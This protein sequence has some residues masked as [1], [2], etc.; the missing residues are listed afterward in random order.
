MLTKVCDSRMRGSAVGWMYRGI[1]NILCLG[2]CQLE[3]LGASH[4]L[5]ILHSKERGWPLLID[6]LAFVPAVC[7]FFDEGPSG[8]GLALFSGG[9]NLRFP[10]ATFSLPNPLTNTSIYRHLQTSQFLS[11]FTLQLAC[12]G[13][14]NILLRF[15]ASSLFFD[16]GPKYCVVGALKKL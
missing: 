10:A 16:H 2:S 13:D 15:I 14:L 12:Q 4:I 1:W 11:G 6:F 7:L 8:T 5:V 9:P 3:R